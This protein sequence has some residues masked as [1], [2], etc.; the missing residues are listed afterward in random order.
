MCECVHV[1]GMFV[2]LCLVLQTLSAVGH[3]VHKWHVCGLVGWLD[4][5]LYNCGFP[6]LIF[7]K[8]P[9]SLVIYPVQVQ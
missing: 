5:R 6:V 9:W 8:Y 1:Y 3:F 2:V 4:E 7:T